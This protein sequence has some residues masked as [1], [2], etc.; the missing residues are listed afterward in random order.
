MNVLFLCT[1]NACRSRTAEELFGALAPSHEYK[2]AGLSYKYV[3][4]E[5]ST[6]C[7]EEMLSWADKIFTFED[8]HI[9]RIQQ[10]TGAQYLY[11]IENLLINDEYVYFQRELVLLLLQ[12]VKIDG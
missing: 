12:R 7:D 9:Q 10:H 2:S 6:L 3:A 1:A 8:M 4:R 11:K 5:N